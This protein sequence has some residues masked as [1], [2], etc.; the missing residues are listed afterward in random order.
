M[1]PKPRHRAGLFYL[2]Y[3]AHRTHY[4]GPFGQRA[5]IALPSSSWLVARF[6]I[7]AADNQFQ[8]PRS[9]RV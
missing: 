9:Y 5:D 1:N 4:L 3:A 6:F 8:M 7:Q 2:R